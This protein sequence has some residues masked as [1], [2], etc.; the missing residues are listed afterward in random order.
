[1]V[2]QRLKRTIFANP[3]DNLQLSTVDAL[4]GSPGRKLVVGMLTQLREGVYYLE[5]PNGQ[6]PIALDRAMFG[7][8]MFTQGSIVLAEGSY[9][10]AEGVFHVDVLLQPPSEGREKSKQFLGNVDLFMPPIVKT[11]S[12]KYSK[13]FGDVVEDAMDVV[14]PSNAEIVILA[15]VHLDSLEVTLV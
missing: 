6:V 12:A 3:K 7:A 2:L 1:M 11:V 4:I 15:E 5:D 9:S 14:V 8:G 10:D 13:L